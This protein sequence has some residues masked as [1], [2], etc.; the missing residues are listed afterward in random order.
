MDL[1]EFI[2]QTNRLNIAMASVVSLGLLWTFI[3]HYNNGG[4]NFRSRRN[5]RARKRF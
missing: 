4:R 1:L 5:K 2:Y 3:A